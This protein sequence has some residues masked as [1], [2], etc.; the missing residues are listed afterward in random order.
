MTY[1]W[2]SVG[3]S[4]D[5]NKVGNEIEEL[6]EVTNVSVLEKAK[7][8]NSELH[9]CFEWDDTVAGD[10]YRLIQASTV[11]SSISIVVNEDTNE[12]KIIKKYVKVY[13]E[14]KEKNKFKSI[15]EV[16]KNDSEYMQIVDK[17]EKEFLDYKKKYESI[18][19]LRDLKDIIFK[20]LG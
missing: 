14:S 10:K 6:E 2:K 20:H 19:Q 17:A 3:Y 4:A 12:E 16:L 1:K 7:D 11:I 5:A 8:K 18:L 9:K 13:D 15:V